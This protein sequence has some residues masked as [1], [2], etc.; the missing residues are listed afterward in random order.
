MMMY[1]VIAAVAKENGDT[2]A[3][4]IH[5][6]QPQRKRRALVT[7]GAGYI[8]KHIV[9]N[10]LNGGH[11]V[12]ASMRDRSREVELRNALYAHLNEPVKDLD[13]LSVVELDL[14]SDVGWEDAFR[15]NNIDVLFHLASPCP[16]EEPKNEDG[17]IRPAIDGA[18]RAV[19]AAHA[20]GVTR[21]IAT[22]SV[23]AVVNCNLS[24]DR[25]EYDETDWTESDRPG[26]SAYVKSKTL[27]ERAIWDWCRE[28]ASEME[29]T[30]ILPSFV[31]GA[32]L[33]GQYGPSVRKVERL[34]RGAQSK[35]PN[36]GYSCVD[37]SDIALMHVRA[38][39]RPDCSVGKRFIGSAKCFLWVPEMAR[40]L[41]DAYP[42]RNI[43]YERASN[44]VIRAKAM[45]N[46][47]YRYVVVNLDKRRILSNKRS[48]QLLDIKFRDPRDSLLETAEYL[49]ANIE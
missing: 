22:S 32:P 19:R 40:M 47:S 48:C 18:L 44:D 43:P 13:R 24:N 5:K 31:L 42:D 10:L 3:A 33:D 38:M 30:T 36:Y 37:V 9:L 1:K 26:I 15:D 28:N 41:H 49:L 7:G 4:T 25:T 39:E 8:G 45:T 11:T 34:L 27:A 23:A 46:P 29:V 17:V 21:V 16:V 12:V 2:E 35:L 20:A 6:M 14:T